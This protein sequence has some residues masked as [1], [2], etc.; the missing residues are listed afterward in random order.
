MMTNAI[1]TSRP[2][3]GGKPSA[4]TGPE[5]RTNTSAASAPGSRNR[6]SRRPVGMSVTAGVP[7]AATGSS[8]IGMSAAVTRR[9]SGRRRPGG[10]GGPSA[11]ALSFRSSG[12]PRAS[13]C[14][15]R[16]VQPVWCEAPIPAPVSPWKYSWNSSRSRHS[17]SS[18][19]F[20]IAPGDGPVAVGVGQPDR[21]SRAGRSAATSRRRRR[22]P[23]PV[24][25]STVNVS[26]SA[27]SQRSIDSMNRKF[28]GNHTGPR[29]LELPPNRLLV[30]SPGS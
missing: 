5:A 26:P 27:S 17:G 1:A 12:P 19:N 29:Q 18:R 3:S 28:T 10:R 21:T 9:H 25:Y 20:A 24:G 11:E 2:I 6:T 15:T 23:E 22:V 4:A 16:P 30:D 13:R 14:A 7:G 8:A